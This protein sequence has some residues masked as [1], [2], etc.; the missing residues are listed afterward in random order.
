MF[1]FIFL[2]FLFLLAFG[3]FQSEWKW[4][5]SMVFAGVSQ[6]EFYLDSRYVR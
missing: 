3:W 2:F 1:F 5:I 6:P 4:N